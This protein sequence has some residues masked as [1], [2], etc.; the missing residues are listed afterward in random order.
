MAVYEMNMKD[1]AR[2]ISDTKFGFMPIDVDST[3]GYRTNGN[4]EYKIDAHK[5]T[6]NRIYVVNDCFLNTDGNIVVT[7]YIPA[8]EYFLNTNELSPYYSSGKHLMFKFE[9]YSQVLR[10]EI[11][12]I[13]LSSFDDFKECMNLLIDFIGENIESTINDF[14]FGEWNICNVD[15]DICWQVDKIK[16]M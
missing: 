11:G 6:C 2:F 8:I 7:S 1:L 13:T 10:Y 15:C 14:C 16:R 12:K 9:A 4:S 5:I 3:I